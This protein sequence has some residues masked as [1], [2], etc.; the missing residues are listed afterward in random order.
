MTFLGAGTT[1]SAVP[2]MTGV[3]MTLC[4][5]EGSK[6]DRGVICAGEQC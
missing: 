3:Y 5:I 6:S 1:K 2:Y 4:E